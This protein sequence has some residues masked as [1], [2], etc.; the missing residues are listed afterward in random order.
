M[1]G[2]RTL[3]FPSC[4]PFRDSRPEPPF[5]LFNPLQQNVAMCLHLKVLVCPPH[6][7]QGLTAPTRSVRK[8][9]CMKHDGQ[10]SQ[11]AVHSPHSYY[12]SYWMSLWQ[13]WMECSLESGNKLL[14]E[15]YRLHAGSWQRTLSARVSAPENG[16]CRAAGKCRENGPDKALGDHPM[17]ESHIDAIALDP[18]KLLVDPAKL[19]Y[20]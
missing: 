1:A 13:H 3:A 4:W 12:R 17:N 19:P 5:H 15:A 9:P 6:T 20:R 18:A 14:V 8:T 7:Q 2:K 16:T 11:I 10:C